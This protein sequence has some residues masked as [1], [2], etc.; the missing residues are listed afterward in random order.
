MQP[1]GKTSQKGIISWFA[2]NHVA[3]NLL[4]VMILALGIMTSFTIRKQVTPD[5]TLDMIS[6]RVPY[7]GAAPEEVEE[8]VVVKIEEAIQD[9]PGIEEIDASY[10]NG[11]LSVSIPSM[12]ENHRKVQ[13]ELK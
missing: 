2:Q 13:I 11:I 3:A 5:F 7:L 4:M 1:T 8:G 12:K 10:K 9:I 6:V